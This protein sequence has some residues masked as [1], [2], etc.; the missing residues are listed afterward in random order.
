MPLPSAS[1]TCPKCGSLLAPDASRGLCAKCLLAGVFEEGPPSAGP[2]T[3]PREFGAYVLHEVVA[4]G[5]MGVVYRARQRPINRTVAL[6]VLAGGQFA[7]PDFVERFKIE[8][9]AA[10]SLDHPNIVPVYEA[11]EWEGQPF[12][13]MKLIEGRSLASRLSD[14]GP[15]MPPSEAAGLTA[16]LARAVHYAHQRG[17]LHRDIKPGNVLLDAQGVPYLTDFGLAKLIEH[18]SGMTRTLAMLG[19]PSYM[20]PEQARGE[21]RELTTAVDVYGLGAM[22]YEVLTGQPPFAG[23]STMETVRQVLEK[24]PQR[25]AALNPAIDPDLDTICLKCLEKDAGLRYGSAEALA[26]DLERWRRHEP[27]LARP[28]STI[29]RSTKWIR[30]NRGAFAAL[31][32][33]GLLVT[34][35]TSVSTWLAVKESTARKEESRQRIA[36]QQAQAQAVAMQRKAELATE[37]ADANLTRAEWLIY[38]GKLMLAQTDF[39]F[40][41]GGLAER[42]LS[43][44]PADLRGWEY[45]YLLNRISP[46]LTLAG[47]TGSVSS[48]V[49][50]PDSRRILT[51]SEDGTAKLWDAATG[52]ELRTL[53]APKGLVFCTAFSP[54]GR[55]I[56]TGTG[57]WWLGRS[58]GTSTVWDAESG[59]PL[60]EIQG[61]EFYV[62][63]LAFSPDG[64][65][66]VTGEGDRDHKAGRAQVWEASTGRHIF[67]LPEEAQSLRGVA[68]SPDG[69]Q[70]MTASISG[71]ST[72]WE[73]A[74]GH[75]LF[76]LMGHRDPVTSVAFSPTDRRF[77]TGG[78][79]GSASVWDSTTGQA[80]LKHTGHKEMVTCVAYRSDGQT[81]ATG[82]SDHTVKVWNSRRDQEI[83]TLKGHSGG[84]RSVAFSPDGAQIATASN[85]RT[86]KVWD[87]GIGQDVPVLKGHTDFISGIAFSPDSRTLVTGG[88]DGL[89]KVWD[90]A[91]G[92]ELLSINGSAPR[93]WSESALW[94]V[95]FSPDVRRILTGSQDKSARIWDAATGQ[96]LLVLHHDTVV[97]CV[98]YSGDGRRVATGVGEPGARVTHPGETRVWDALTGRELARFPHPSSVLA[99]AFSPDGQRVAAA[100]GDGTTSILD[101][102]TGRELLTLRHASTVWSVAYSGDGRFIITGSWDK[103]AK[104]WDATTGSERLTLAGHTGFVRGAAFSPDGQRIVTSSDD[105][106]V[107]IWHAATGREALTLPKHTETVLSLAF[108]P[109]GRH[110]ATGIAGANAT[111]KVWSA[112]LPP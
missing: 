80:L 54:D 58:P 29:E 107:K 86:A 3:L 12:F 53:S 16:T 88:G 93:A 81:I 32:V 102:A 10:S 62:W 41:N 38:A 6:K 31:C 21:A 28:S 73:A 25:P 76:S 30:R 87:A 4:R 85:D 63:S 64:Q 59:R 109:D 77:V 75:R 14:P 34:A 98:A 46:R 101:A 57:D 111:V 83:F 35:G 97:S 36:A 92:R 51:G 82:S 106:T 56:A 5:G 2:G 90:T 20:S 9:D 40:G 13:S 17:V 79:D 15:P 110:L 43:E 23:G 44:C 70:I 103:T 8:A 78:W 91:T 72:M 66:L 55:R 100:T 61:H 94:G 68:L 27:I 26:D 67:S 19:T 74:T 108:S 95:A 71:T 105:R 47:H 7:A 52:R 84:V 11:G 69:R 42:H 37:Q 99:V 104:V 49:F 39:E 112:T 1:L 48:V 60:L 89:A 45:F 33:I 24:D 22:F 18:D 50:S 65:R 96:E